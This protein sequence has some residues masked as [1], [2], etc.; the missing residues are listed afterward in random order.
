MPFDFWVRLVDLT[1]IV[2]ILIWRV[3]DWTHERKQHK[4]LNDLLEINTQI[5][6]H[7]VKDEEGKG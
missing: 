4:A 1:A 5:L 7:L 6:N 3:T 2:S